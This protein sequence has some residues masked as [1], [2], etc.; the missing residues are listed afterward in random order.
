LKTQCHYHASI[1]IGGEK[2][3]LG[4]FRSP[5]EGMAAFDA[6]AIKLHGAG[7]TTNVT[8]GL[9]SAK[10]AR[11]RVCRKAARH[12]RNKVREHQLKVML[13][14]MEALEAAS[15]TK[16]KAAIFWSMVSPSV[17]VASYSAAST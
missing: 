17:Q 4:S 7:T 6:A 3:H 15:T 13:A 16:E 5:E 12:A 14:K 1:S 9:L 10:V 11:T 2:V 8:L